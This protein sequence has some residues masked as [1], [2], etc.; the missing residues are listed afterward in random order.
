MLKIANAVL[1][2]SRSTT[3]KEEKMPAKNYF[4]FLIP[5]SLLVMSLY[6]MMNGFTLVTKVLFM[7]TCILNIGFSIAIV[8]KFHKFK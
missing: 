1:M 4:L 7:V 2:I 6:T 5:V 3:I 8:I